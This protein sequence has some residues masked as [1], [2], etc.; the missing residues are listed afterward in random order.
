MLTDHSNLQGF[1]KV[2]C[3]NARQLR[4]SLQLNAIDFDTFHRAGKL[5]PA[6]GPSRKLDCDLGPSSDNELLLTLQNK[7]KLNAYVGKPA[8]GTDPQVV[9]A[10][11]TRLVIAGV[12]VVIS[13]R[14]VRMLP[15]TPYEDTP[16]P[17]GTLIKELQGHDEWT[18]KLTKN[19]TAPEGRRRK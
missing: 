14:E 11:R 2:Q 3:L 18:N 17:M 8:D 19:L 12:K 5:N 13:R 7:L 16:R 4:W 6:D 9:V 15:D 1:N 10:I